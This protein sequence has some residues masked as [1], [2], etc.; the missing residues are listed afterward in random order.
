MRV[1]FAN[2]G[3]FI[4]RLFRPK[5]IVQSKEF[6]DKQ[7]V[8]LQICDYWVTRRKRRSLSM[9]G[10]EAGVHLSNIA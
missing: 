4:L 5:A 2:F 1:H 7:P 3:I 6:E 8:C 10:C 9:I